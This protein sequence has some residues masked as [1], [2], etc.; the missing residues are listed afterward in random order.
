MFRQSAPNTVFSR[1]S[2]RDKTFGWL[3]SQPAIIRRSGLR[4][5]QVH[6]RYQLAGGEDVV[7]QAERRLLE[8]YG[9]EVDVLDAD[10]A[11]ITGLGGRAKAALGAI[12]SPAAKALVT[13][14]IESFRPH[15][16]HV[17]N[18]FPLFS[19]SVY[20]ACQQA[21]VPVAQTVHN[22]RLICPNS[23]LLRDG[24]VCEDCVGK[25]FPWPGVLHA[26]YRNSP[27][28]SASVAAMIAI[29]HQ[30][31]TW[32]NKVDAFIA[33]TNFSRNKLIEGGLPAEKII[34]KPNF[35]HDPGHVSD[36]KNSF[37]LFVGRLSPEK[38]IATLLT[39]WE[40]LPGVIPLKVVGTGPLAE[41]IDQRSAPGR[42]EP[43]GRQPSEKI[44]ALMRD[45]SF[46]VFPSVWYEGLPM[47]IVEAFSVGLPVIAS[48]LGSMTSLVE[49]GRT[50]LHFRPGDAADLAEKVEWAVAHHD[51]IARMRRDAR[52]EYVAKYTPERN[53]EMLMAIYRQVINGRKSKTVD[54][55]GTEIVG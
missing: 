40:H 27:A 32:A 50:G 48:N 9:H 38:G 52:A 26:C 25:Q 10:N 21:T 22:Y 15:V 12:Y 42:V 33:T 1:H 43:L 14:R 4:V 8:Q 28:G 29:H 47:V 36:R 39:A 18:F 20:Y 51:E 3:R 49:H 16:V 19:P 41:E 2:H 6:N 55:S 34:V 17:H 5:L 53:Y 7:T 54:F 44:Q 35:V 11:E 13:A 30:L 45:A 37:A 24:H 23:Q 46:L 31:G